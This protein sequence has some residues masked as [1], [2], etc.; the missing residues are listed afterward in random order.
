VSEEIMESAVAKWLKKSS[1]VV[2]RQIPLAHARLDVVAYDKN[3]GIFKVV[4]CKS[5]ISHTTVGKTFGQLLTYLAKIQ[6]Q[7]DEFVDAV[8]DKMMMRFQRWMEA[9]DGGKKIR[10][11][12]FVALPQDALKN[13]S[14]LRDL[15]K[16][17][18]G[19]GIIRFK[20]DGTCKDF[21][22]EGGVKNHELTRAETRPILLEGRWASPS[23]RRA[24]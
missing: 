14:S 19:V 9:T 21:V 20:K 13:L 2:A 11:E 15:R 3:R 18:P 6:N 23:V 22:R 7:P 10:I 16:Q 1:V 4:E 12:L 17:Y 5:T 24:N 8:S